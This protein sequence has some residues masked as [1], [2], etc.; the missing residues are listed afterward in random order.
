VSAIRVVIADDHTLVLEAFKAMLSDRVDVVVTASDGRELIKI[1]RETEPDVV[2][3]DIS[4]PGLNGFDAS[5]KLL[6]YLPD[7]KLIFLT[8]SDDPDMVAQAIRSGAK[9][10]LL[11]SSAVSELLQAIETVAGGETY[12]TPLVTGEALDDLISGKTQGQLEQLTVRQREIL[13]LIAEGHTMKETARI[14][15][16]APRTVAF[17]KYR[18]M[19]NLGID[20]SAELVRYA[21]KSGLLQA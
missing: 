19:E 5:M 13:Q 1:V 2:V 17:H 12:I 11:K 10:Y 21:Y 6:K 3:T 20:N 8:V 4:M 7:L 15:S 9:G 16:L 18:I 14:L